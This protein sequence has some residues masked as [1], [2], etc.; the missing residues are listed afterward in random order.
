MSAGRPV[1]ARKSWPRRLKQALRR[2]L[3]EPHLLVWLILGVLVVACMLA[4]PLFLKPRNLR[5]VFLIQPIGLGLASLGQAFVVI[6]G[7]IDLSIGAVMS[8]LSSLAA[9]LFRAQPGVPALAVGLLLAG[10]GAAAGA[11]NGFI[12]VRLRVPPFMATLATMS[13]FQGAVLFYAPK[14][15]GGIPASFRFLA[16]G[17]LAGVPFS[18]VLFVL[19]I[20]ACYYLLSGNRLGRH[21]YAVGADP[22]VSQISGIPVRRVRFLSYLIC[23]LLVGV[24][25]AFMAARLGGGG[26]KVGVGYELDSITAVVIGGVSLAG[27][28]G[29]LLGT[30]AGVLIIGVF[31]NIMNL[32][33]VNAY[34]QIVLKGVVLI[35]AVSFYAKRRT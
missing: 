32:L 27:G 15:I 25:A 31:Y 35:L 3:L 1:P 2:G 24:A 6:A 11:L 16:E 20:A 4:T 12:V 7:G 10:L 18:I 22:Y 14:T 5:N 13:L 26:P 23:G 9:G 19:I 29:N 8:L 30:F 21:L 33:N 28:A 34:L 17:Q